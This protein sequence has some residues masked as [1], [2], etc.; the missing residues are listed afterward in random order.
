MSLR[1]LVSWIN[2][3]PPVHVCGSTFWKST[4]KQQLGCRFDIMDY[5]S[6]FFGILTD[7]LEYLL[8]NNN[9]IFRL[10]LYILNSVPFLSS[11][12]V[13]TFSIN[14]VFILPIVT[15]YIHII[16]II[17]IIIII[18]YTKYFVLSWC[19]DLLY[20]F[21]LYGIFQLFVSIPVSSRSPSSIYWPV[22]GQKTP[23]GNGVPTLNFHLSPS[24]C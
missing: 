15:Y 11:T 7:E 9:M 5:R 12:P 4:F 10:C 17:I 21:L 22:V 14:V 18:C 6:S 19:I 24:E 8:I 2:H 1:R 3:L 13:P 23:G 16:I 20:S